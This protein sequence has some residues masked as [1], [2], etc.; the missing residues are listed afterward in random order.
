MES[1]GHTPK[2]CASAPRAQAP[3]ASLPP[4]DEVFGGSLDYHYAFY[5]YTTRKG[6]RLNASLSTPPPDWGLRLHAHFL[7]GPD[8]A[9]FS[10]KDLPPHLVPFFA[11]KDT[12]VYG[13][14]SGMLAYP[15]SLFETIYREWYPTR[16]RSVFKYGLYHSPGAAFFSS[17][18]R[19]DFDAPIPQ[20]Q[21]QLGLLICYHYALSRRLHEI[22]PSFPY[23]VEGG[24]MLVRADLSPDELR[25]VPKIRAH[26]PY[27]PVMRRTL[28]ECFLFIDGKWEEHGVRLV[29]L[30]EDMLRRMLS[31][32]GYAMTRDFDIEEEVK[33]V[34]EEAMLNGQKGLDEHDDIDVK[35]QMNHVSIWK[36]KLVDAMRAV[37]GGDEARKP[38]RLDYNWELQEWLG[39]GVPVGNDGRPLTLSDDTDS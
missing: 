39:E 33:K 28:S 20:P 35:A 26:V 22:L 32:D 3:P 36:G 37:V 7:R 9:L 18:V 25:A 30:S 8:L 6:H 5:G 15:F 27:T 23:L 29:V 13:S 2:G 24:K 34:A 11:F 21:V 19:V 4:L 14:S 16:D 10:T 12:V 38:G 17:T 31:E 1:E